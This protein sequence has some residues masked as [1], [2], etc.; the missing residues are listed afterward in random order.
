MQ[1][2]KQG[3]KLLSELE[4]CKLKPY[5]DTKGVPTIGVGTTIYPDGT[6]VT[7]NDKPITEEQAYEYC[8]YH[9]NKEVI[10][11][12]QKAIKVEQNQNQIDALIIFCYNIG[13]PRFINSTLV[14]YI[15]KKTIIEEI[16]DAWMM[17]TKNKEL[18]GRRK[19]EIA[20]YKKPI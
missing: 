4:G 12:I 18:I 7:L 16:V 11:Y 2:S 19:K 1:L 3:F 20:L 17:W 10:P 14:K 5:L 15:N 6:R 8:N 9:I 13:W